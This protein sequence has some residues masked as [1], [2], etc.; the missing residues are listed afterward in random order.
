MTELI[1]ASRARLT[2]W[3][4]CLS[5]QA[6]PKT[7][8]PR[9]AGKTDTLKAHAQLEAALCLSSGSMWLP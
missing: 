6:A 1:G 9:L 7:G 2:V 5:H 3:D 4:L 8:N